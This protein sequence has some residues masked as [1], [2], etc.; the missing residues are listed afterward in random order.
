MSILTKILNFFGIGEKPTEVESAPIVPPT[1]STVHTPQC[2][3]DCGHA[4]P[5]TT[6]LN[7]AAKAVETQVKVD[8][9]IVINTVPVA[10]ITTN[11]A[12]VKNVE[13]SASD[14]PTIKVPSKPVQVPKGSKKRKP[15]GAKQHG[16]KLH[17]NSDRDIII[18]P[19]PSALYLAADDLQTQLVSPSAPVSVEVPVKPSYYDVD[20]CA[21]E[22]A[23]SR[24]SDL[25]CSPASN[26]SS[27]SPTVDY[28]SSSSSDCG[29]GGCGGGGD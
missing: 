13:V 6:K 19:D 10:T 20:E 18:N 3:A 12:A 5:A 16:A 15:H 9:D 2:G 17:S 25:G 22:P 23:R 28:S 21:A 7:P 29:G 24:N 4:V 26:Y 11:S 14:K 27:P 1:I 8:Q